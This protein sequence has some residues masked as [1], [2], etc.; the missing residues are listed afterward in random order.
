MGVS[1]VRGEKA[2]ESPRV[3]DIR[4][5]LICTEPMV[6][7]PPQSQEEGS[8]VARKEFKERETQTEQGPGR[9]DRIEK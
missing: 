9:E 4:G 3:E 1:Q 5:Q 2:G 7:T 8:S 6:L